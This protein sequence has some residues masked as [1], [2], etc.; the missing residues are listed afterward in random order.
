MLGMLWLLLAIS[1][2]IYY[3]GRYVSDDLDF[4][5]LVIVIV[6]G[7]M[8]TAAGLFLVGRIPGRLVVTILAS[9]VYGIREF[10]YLFHTWPVPINADS[11][12]GFMILLF[13]VCTIILVIA[14]RVAVRRGA[15][16]V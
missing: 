15:P 9:L 8:G 1:I 14:E 4:R 7:L 2:L 10:T 13:A 11:V 3:V 16:A 12:R 5:S 6:Y